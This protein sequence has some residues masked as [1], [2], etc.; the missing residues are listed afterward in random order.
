M[1]YERAVQLRAAANLY[2]NVLFKTLGAHFY[3]RIRTSLHTAEAAVHF[4]EFLVFSI[5]C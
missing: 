4:A 3:A 2:Q 5:I 1:A